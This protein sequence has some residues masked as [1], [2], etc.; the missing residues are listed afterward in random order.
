MSIIIFV[1][2]GEAETNRQGV[3]SAGKDGFPLTNVGIDQIRVIARQLSEIY[4][5]KIY[6]SP[7]YRARQTAEILNEGRGKDI[8]I[9][10]R[11]N[12]RHFGQ[13][14]GKPSFGSKWNMQ[15]LIKREYTNGV[16]TYEE[17]RDRMYSFVESLPEDGTFLAATHE[18]PIDALA[19]SLFGFDEFSAKGMQVKNA[20]VTVLK[21]EHGALKLI[22]LGSFSIDKNYL[23]YLLGIK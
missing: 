12:E 14:E 1:R 17:I 19:A 23:D 5:D 8:I 20:S 18:S 2:H 21:K 13:L 3:L 9:D 6:S 7:V 15:M 10:E 11:L 4:V 16:E 22:A